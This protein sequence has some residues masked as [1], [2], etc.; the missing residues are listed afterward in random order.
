[1]NPVRHPLVFRPPVRLMMCKP[2]LLLNS[3]SLV[4]LS[5]LAV[6]LL[7][8]RA[9]PNVVAVI[10]R[11]TSTMFWEAEHAGAAFAAR[12][13]GIRIKWNA[14]TRE[15]DVQLQIGMVERAIGERC[16]GLILAPDE[17]R[18][19]MVPIQRALAAGVPTVVIGSA[20][21]LPAQRNLSYIVN[22]NEM[23]GGIAG[24]RIGEVL[25]GKGEVAIVGVNPQSDSSLAVLRS[26]MSVMEDQFPDIEVVDRRAG[27]N[28]DLDSELIVGE[29]LASHPKISAIFSLDATGT[30][31][32]YLALKGRSLTDRVK[33][34]GVQQSAELINAIRLH[35]ID[36]LVAEDTY[37]MG[38]RAVELL[39]QR[40]SVSPYVIKLAPILITASNVDAPETKRFVTN[41]W[42]VELQ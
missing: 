37:Q 27:T 13:S 38:F 31:G 2:K 29:V 28:S 9:R 33:I 19:L 40:P 22:D 41:D 18:A 25:H 21:S 30:V 39:T 24:E 34:V 5:V 15:D 10:P 12:K 16:R 26:F 42:R 4:C 20:L 3:A 17:P 14:P 7:S 36:A 35:Q 23:I 6:V 8:C 1:M 32:A 11:T